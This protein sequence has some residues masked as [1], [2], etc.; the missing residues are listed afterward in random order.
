MN[1]SH[2]VDIP[3]VDAVIYPDATGQSNLQGST[4]LS[5]FPPVALPDEATELK[6]AKVRGGSHYSAAV[7]TSLAMEPAYPSGAYIIFRDYCAGNHFE[8]EC[9][10]C[11]LCDGRSEAPK[12]GEVVFAFLSIR[13]VGATKWQPIS[14]IRRFGH[15]AEGNITLTPDAPSFPS[16]TVGTKDGVE[17]KADVMGIA[18][19]LKPWGHHRTE[20]VYCS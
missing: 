1:T 18:T 12:D 9:E 7:P 20:G 10:W 8:D 11:L 6:N 19:T 4:P 15:D 14:C 2:F 16:W 3:I 13:P 5:M 17:V